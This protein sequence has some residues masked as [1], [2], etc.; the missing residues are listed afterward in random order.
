[1]GLESANYLLA[2]R[3]G[4]D[5]VHAVLA[6]LGAEE[7]TSFQGSDF[8]RWVIRNDESWIDV[9]AGNFGSEQSPAVS[10]RIA[11]SNPVG[12]HVALRR[13]LG[14]LLEHVPGVLLDKQSRRS[15]TQLDDESWREIE[16]ALSNKRAD[17]QRNFG[18]FEAAISGEDVFP[19]L[20]S[21]D[22]KVSQ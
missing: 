15:Y 3:D 2:P 8:P 21:R 5:T 11:L 7:R 18:P 22:G 19:A 12:A 14:V 4:I 17:F 16:S 13:L 10:I 1:M 20:R 6:K 9:M